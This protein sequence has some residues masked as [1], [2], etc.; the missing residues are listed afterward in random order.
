MIIL[1]THSWIWLEI[2][3]EQIPKPILTAMETESV[4]GISAV[5]LLQ[6]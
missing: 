5:S 1:D 6:G 2:E 3:P 4:W